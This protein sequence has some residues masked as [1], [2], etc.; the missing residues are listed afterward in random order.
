VSAI[1]TRRNANDFPLYL[2]LMC[3]SL[4]TPAE[5]EL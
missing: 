3:R 5:T 1:K 2:P 4:Q